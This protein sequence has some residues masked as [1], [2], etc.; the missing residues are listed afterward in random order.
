MPMSELKLIVSEFYNGYLDDRKALKMFEAEYDFV[1]EILEEPEHNFYVGF[2][3]LD[4]QGLIPEGVELVH[5][6]WMKKLQES[7]KEN[8]IVGP[9]RR[10]IEQN[11]LVDNETAA[12][13]HKTYL[14]YYSFLY[15]PEDL[16]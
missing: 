12:D 13:I 9:I 11:F 14:E 16:L 6:I 7:G 2:N 10:L 3:S 8:M 15:H 4:E 5:L 1:P